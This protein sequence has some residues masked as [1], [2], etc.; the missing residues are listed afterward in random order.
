MVGNSTT[1]GSTGDETISS[2]SVDTIAYLDIE[3]RMTFSARVIQG[4]FLAQ[5]LSVLDTGAGRGY[6]ILPSSSIEHFKLN[7][8]PIRC[9]VNMANGRP[10]IIKHQFDGELEIANQRRNV[11]LRVLLSETE[12]PYLLFGRDLIESFGLVTHGARRIMMGKT[13]IFNSE[14]DGL[15]VIRELEENHDTLSSPGVVTLEPPDPPDDSVQLPLSEKDI[16]EC[17]RLIAKLAEETP[18]PLSYCP[19]VRM[20]LRTL[21]DKE[22]KDTPLQKYCFEINA[23]IVPPTGTNRLYAK[24]CYYRLSLPHRLEFDKLVEDYVLK[25]WWTPA[26]RQECQSLYGH[27]ANV[28]GV[29]QSD[30]LRL[31]A[32]FR[33]LNVFYPASTVLPSIPYSILT[34]GLGG[35]SGL[36]IGDCRSAF[37]RVRLKRGYWLH[38]G[39]RDFISCRMSFGLSFGPE[40]LRRSV[41]QLW[42]LIRALSSDRGVGS[43][44]VDDWF[45]SMVTGIVM[46]SSARFLRLLA[47]TG[48]DCAAKKFQIVKPGETARLFHCDIR[49]HRDST[50][51]DCCRKKRI[52]NTKQLIRK[53][54]W[55]KSEIFEI[56]GSLG[57]DPTGTH[58]QERLVADLLRALVG[59]TFSTC[60][61]KSTLDLD[62]LDMTDRKLFHSLLN[63]A[64]EFDSTCDHHIPLDRGDHRMQF[65][66]QVDASLLGRG[67]CLRFRSGNSGAWTT[68]LASC[69]AWGRKESAYSINRLEGI[70]LCIAMRKT[71]TFLTQFRDSEIGRHHISLFVQTDNSSALKWATKGPDPASAKSAVEWRSIC[72]L[73]EGLEQEVQVLHE[74]TDSF[75]M[76]HIPGD[77]NIIA[78][79]LSRL[80]QRPVDDCGLSVGELFRR[81]YVKEVEQVQVVKEAELPLSERI[82]SV[83]DNL[84]DAI[85]LFT[86]VRYIFRHKGGGFDRKSSSLSSS[87]ETQHQLIIKNRNRNRPDGSRTD[88]TVDNHISCGISTESD[89]PPQLVP[90]D[91][92]PPVFEIGTDDEIAFFRNAQLIANE[93]CKNACIIDTDGTLRF[94]FSRYD[95]TKGSLI[96][97]SSTTPHVQ[98]LVFKHYHL[99]N[100][101]RGRR[102]TLGDISQLF[103]L[104][105]ANRIARRFIS[106][107]LLCAKK[108]SASFIDPV[109][110]VTTKQ[111]LIH[112]PL[113]TRCAIDHLYLRPTCLSII[114]LDTQFF[115]LIPVKSLT[116]ADTIKALSSIAHRY[117]VKFKTIVCDRYSGL[118]SPELRRQLHSLG[119]DCEIELVPPG[120]SQLNPVERPHLSVWSILRCIRNRGFVKR[121]NQSE[122]RDM[123]TVID[124]SQWLDEISYI[125]NTRPI[126][127]DDSSSIVTPAALA[128]GPPH[129][130]HDPNI[131]NRLREVREYFYNYCFDDL[132]R[133]FSSKKARTNLVQ[134]GR[135]VLV[136]IKQSFKGEFP[137]Q[138]ARIVSIDGAKITV[139]SAKKIFEVSS[140]QVVPLGKYFQP[141]Q[142]ETNSPPGEACRGFVGDESVNDTEE[143]RESGIDPETA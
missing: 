131:Q 115:Q 84:M 109:L 110:P 93:K 50:Q 88:I 61:W 138:L 24:S 22:S 68:I 129:G 77:G 55:N 9:V 52:L 7:L 25:G 3:E 5:Y 13:C 59:G 74:L 105:N 10:V 136:R 58:A 40:G 121:L 104:Q 134:V 86:K 63:W 108:N 62:R 97:I 142:D 36:V 21:E 119:H 17:D 94:V 106:N 85:T 48:F 20:T 37:L 101:H 23:P 137:V 90:I 73:S 60:D 33:P 128:F 98:R 81:R 39:D 42:Q 71:A 11:Q 143:I 135:L 43:L 117:C 99:L 130:S 2:S 72:R 27:A 32:D 41:G 46:R 111:R 35:Q 92:P 69:A 19:G 38:C 140:T 15:H 91:D 65:L 127:Y 95:G 107:C 78:D 96:A 120:A 31:V 126:G 45:L 103:Y 87:L 16:I 102:H 64:N 70:S 51:V 118:K 29:V 67:D 139:K 124:S 132:R 53:G 34:L 76:S 12:E 57:Y 75:E 82:A 49:V 56:A 123:D 4:D 26:G 54:S 116:T 122:V 1:S 114:C 8:S 83:S 28:F 141:G 14:R 44:F 89:T 125:I 113:F 133:R 18:T 100:A 66:L 80:L 79:S 47:V 6:L 112:L 30:K